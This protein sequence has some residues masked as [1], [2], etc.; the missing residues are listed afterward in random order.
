MEWMPE[1]KA[2]YELLWHLGGSQSDVASL[3][4]E[5]IRWE[6]RIISYSRKKT[7]RSA[8]L[9]FSSSVATILKAAPTIG[10]PVPEDISDA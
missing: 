6:D 7:G 3:R 8:L 10:S 9:R 2:F 1:W 5:D 4:A